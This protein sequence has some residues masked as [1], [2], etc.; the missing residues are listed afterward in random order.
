MG[1]WSRAP[2][3]SQH[4]IGGQLNLKDFPKFPDDRWGNIGKTKSQPHCCDWD[5]QTLSI[6]RADDVDTL[7]GLYCFILTFPL[8][9]MYITSFG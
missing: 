6:I 1:S 8:A 5:F 7:S 9:S 4:K 2:L 3:E